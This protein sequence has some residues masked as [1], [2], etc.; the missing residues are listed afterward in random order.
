M[1]NLRCKCLANHG[2]V[3]DFV[4]TFEFAILKIETLSI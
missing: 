3:V 4:E 1:L 2:G